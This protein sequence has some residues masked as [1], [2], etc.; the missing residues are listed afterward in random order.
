MGKGGWSAEDLNLATFESASNINP[1]YDEKTKGFSLKALHT[2]QS[3]VLP[4]YMG[5]YSTIYSSDI[6]CYK[7]RIEQICHY[8]KIGKGG[9]ITTRFPFGRKI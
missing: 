9:G 1:F 3:S 7:C 5:R 4:D 6:T 2:T 8:P